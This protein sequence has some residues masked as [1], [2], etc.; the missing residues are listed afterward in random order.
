MFH[1]IQDEGDTCD[2][3]LL[4]I[5]GFIWNYYSTLICYKNNSILATTKIA[6][7]YVAHLS[8]AIRQE[9]FCSYW[10]IRSNINVNITSGSLFISY[11]YDIISIELFYLCV[12]CWL[13][14]LG[15]C[16]SAFATVFSYL[17]CILYLGYILLL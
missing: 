7:S 17:G 12:D 14:L 2:I 13:L 8:F 11:N 16:E 3:I 10:P 9:Y 6:F 1:P 5:F 15:N 4:P